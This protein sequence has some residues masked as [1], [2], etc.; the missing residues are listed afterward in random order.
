MMKLNLLEN[1][2]THDDVNILKAIINALNLN[3]NNI[4]PH[5]RLNKKSITTNIDN[6]QIKFIL[7]NDGKS[8]D[9][10]LFNNKPKTISPLQQLYINS[11]LKNNTNLINPIND[12]SNKPTFN[13]AKEFNDALNIFTQTI[14][15]TIM[16]IVKMNNNKLS[17]ILFCYADFT[18]TIELKIEK[19]I[20]YVREPENSKNWELF[21]NAPMDYIIEIANYLIL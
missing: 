16:D 15:N 18:P 1:K 5:F 7:N 12:N 19:N 6:N 14:E 8:I 3:P 13:S 9:S 11:Q 2:I 10:I 21:K 17:F 4:K 20:L